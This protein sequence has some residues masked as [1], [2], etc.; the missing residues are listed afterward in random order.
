MITTLIRDF[1]KQVGQTV[2]VQGW[3]YNIRSSGKITFLQIRDGSGFTQAIVNQASVDPTTWQTAT[4]LTIESS[5]TLAGTV[6]QHPKKQEYELQ[7][8][9]ITP[10]QLATAEFPIGKKEHGPDFL[11]EKRH[12]WLRS[13]SQWAVLRLRHFVKTGFQDYF[14]NQGYIELDTPTFTPTSCEGTS[15]LFE[16]EYFDR[17]AYLT[18]NGQL[19]L[20]AMCMAFGKVYDLCPNF[21]AE[22]SKTRKHLTEFWSLN[23]EIAFIDHEA[24]LKIQEAAIKHMLEYVLQHARAELALLQRDLT[25]LQDTMAKP[26]VHYQYAEAIVELQKRGSSIQ[27]GE[28]LGADDEVLLTADSTVPVIVKN[29][30]RSIKPFYMKGYPY[31]NKTADHD[32]VLNADVLAPRG[33]GEIIGGSQREDDYETLLAAMQAARLP[34]KDFDWYLEL[35]KFGSVPHCGFGIG[36]ERMTRWVAGV[37]HIRETIPFPRMINRIT[38]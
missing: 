38:P 33:F 8:T 7:V 30:P 21:R 9:A 10:I 2:M 3:V 19:Y 32:L 29:W 27:F 13:Q 11:L 6:S 16:V 4:Q 12:L 23:P 1:S 14:N 25:D 34:L 20:E 5:L 35:R 22:K 36:I 31:I 37:H 17:K 15:D 26:I 24:S 28:D 18:Q